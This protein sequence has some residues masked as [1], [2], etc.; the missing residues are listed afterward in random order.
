MQE[1]E[2]S[3]GKKDKKEKKGKKDK[4][5]KKGK[6]GKKGK[7]EDEVSFSYS[8]VSSRNHCSDYYAILRPC[9]SV[10]ILQ[11]YN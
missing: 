2:K 8:F 11:S 9:L 5:E 4:K 10:F 6:K 7:A 3:K 1:D